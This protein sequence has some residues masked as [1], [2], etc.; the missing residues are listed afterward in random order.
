MYSVFFFFSSRKPETFLTQSVVSPGNP[1]L[2]IFRMEGE[3]A[4]QRG[5]G[6][7]ATHRLELRSC[8]HPQEAGGTHCCAGSLAPPMPLPPAFSCTSLQQ[9]ERCHQPENK[10]RHCRRQ[11]LF[12][13]P[14]FHLHAD[15]SVAEPGRK[16]QV[17]GFGIWDCRVRAFMSGSRERKRSKGRTD[18]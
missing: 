1:A 5:Q 8:P 16:W 13:E 17:S 15:L 7:A 3:G 2:C 4:T 6:A 12:P 10:N 18:P 9:C 11:M 14:P